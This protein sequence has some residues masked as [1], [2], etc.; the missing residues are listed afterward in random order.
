MQNQVNENPIETYPL[1]EKN[2]D[3]RSYLEF[4]QF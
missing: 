2:V 4:D 1:Y 3:L